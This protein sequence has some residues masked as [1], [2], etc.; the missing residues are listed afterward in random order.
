MNS[1]IVGGNENGNAYPD[2]QHADDAECDND[3]DWGEERLPVLETLLIEGVIL[4]FKEDAER[5]PL[6]LFVCCSLIRP[7]WE[8]DFVCLCGCGCF[9]LKCGVLFERRVSHSVME[10]R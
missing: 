9:T 6:G 4:S 8:A 2:K 3:I 7:E 10:N 1:Y 5:I